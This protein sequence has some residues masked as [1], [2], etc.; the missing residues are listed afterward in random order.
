M[1]KNIIYLFTDSGHMYNS[2][3]PRLAD[4]ADFWYDEQLKKIKKLEDKLFQETLETL[5][6]KAVEKLNK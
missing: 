5:R 4:E 3:D 2:Q 1:N 6:K